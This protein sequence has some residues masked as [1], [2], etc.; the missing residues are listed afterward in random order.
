M[1]IAANFRYIARE[2]LRGKWLIAVIA[3]LIAFLL[4]GLGSEGL[5]VKLNID[6][7]G[8]MVSFEVAGMTIL[9]TAGGVNEYL[10]A[11][12]AGGVLLIA[13]AAIVL[14][15][16]YFVLGSVIEAGY[17]R[18]NLDLVDRIEAKL[19]TLF[20]YFYNWKTTAATRFLVGLYTLLW[21]LLFVIPG[22]MASYSYA[23]TGYILAEH[24][25]LT[26]GEAIARSKEMMS[27][28][29]F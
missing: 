5:D 18:Y 19:E 1:K 14:T 6:M 26:A 2:A 3:G 13:V 25:E 8:S 9:S 21:S 20:T 22:I 10:S 11:F 12:L 16:V 29:R 7:S 23:M 15:V 28:N 24:P 17:A 27:G 4:G